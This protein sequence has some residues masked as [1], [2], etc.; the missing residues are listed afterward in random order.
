MFGL[1]V[2]AARLAAVSAPAV[3]LRTASV[4][5]AP[6]RASARAVSMPIPEAAPVTMMRLPE[7]LQPAT[8]SSAV[9]RAP[10]GVVMG[11]IGFLPNFAVPALP[12]P[13]AQTHL[14][15][16]S[17]FV[18][19]AGAHKQ[20]KAGVLVS[21]RR[22]KGVPPSEAGRLMKPSSPSSASPLDSWAVTGEDTLAC[23][24][25][26]SPDAERT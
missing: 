21:N 25:C 26:A 19:R 7:R 1:P 14:D 6:V 10:N 20:S 13:D 9:D 18:P 24:D 12:D 5:S 22:L 4:T 2:E 8:T 23:G 17:P 16:S 11:A 3:R 15:A